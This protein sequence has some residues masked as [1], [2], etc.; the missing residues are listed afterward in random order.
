M[1][2]ISKTIVYDYQAQTA[3]KR[4]HSPLPTL[5]IVLVDVGTLGFTILLCAAVR[6]IFGG[7]YHLPLY[8]QLWPLLGLFV[9][10]FTLYGLYPG[11]IVN[12]IIE[13]RSVAAATTTVYLILGVLTFMLRVSENYSRIVFVVAW[14][15]SL[16]FVPIARAL[17]RHCLCRKSWWGYRTLVLIG[18][19]RGVR[20]L[21]SLQ[22]QP[23][24][25]LRV[26][27]VLNYQAASDPADHSGPV[28]E[29]WEKAPILAAHYGITHAIL[30]APEFSAKQLRKVLDS[31][32]RPFTHLYVVPD[33]EG[34]SSLGIGAL[35]LGH[36]LA[37]EVSNRL[38][39]SSAGLI[40]RAMDLLISVALGLVLLP[41]IG[42]IALL[43]KLESKGPA[44]YGH[45][46]IGRGEDRFK[47][48]KFRSMVVDADEVLAAHLEERPE[49]K[50]E[51][52]RDRK[53]KDDPRVTRVGRFLRR[54][55][56][57]ELPQLW[58]VIKG[59]M[60]LVGPRPIVTEEIRSYDAE[61]D[62]YT[63]VLPGITGLW[64]VSGR[65]DVSYGERVSLDTYYVRNWSPWLDIYI[66]ARTVKV[67]FGC[68]GAY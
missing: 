45:L 61:F 46:R 60:S 67:V 50:Q 36:V 14:L 49:L 11:V 13:I 20:L 57:D 16:A 31:D 6:Q 55:S 51:W 24:L 65:S 9:A 47:L 8:S 52:L 41:V 68:H 5:L 34:L 62:L 42:L 1:A 15:L 3:I 32:A 17:V 21:R 33:L 43:I 10:A 26:A 29:G 22:K 37:L 28:F 58:N 38:L 18:D 63:Q 44:F 4:K 25:G 30:A 40:K 7:Q 27:A 56:L 54:T 66:L 53:L 48:W 35:D 39:L 23:E 2:T 12:P 19:D 64:Q 59:D